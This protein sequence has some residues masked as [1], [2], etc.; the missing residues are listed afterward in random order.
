M[1]VTEN[2]KPGPSPRLSVR[3][4]LLLG[5][6]V[7]AGVV[8]LVAV[9][10]GVVAASLARDAATYAIV[11]IGFYVC[12]VGLVAFHLR[13]CFQ[14]AKD[15]AIRRKLKLVAIFFALTVLTVVSNLSDMAKLENK[16]YLGMATDI[17]V[18]LALVFSLELVNALLTR[19]AGQPTTSQEPAG[20]AGSNS[21]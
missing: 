12:M 8:L 16:D 9:A 10:A 18:Y 21:A 15:P 2:P 19:A 5:V 3:V 1:G 17:G 14:S 6:A 13:A 7:A 11:R 4:G 20:Q